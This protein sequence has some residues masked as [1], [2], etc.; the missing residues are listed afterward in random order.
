MEVQ[1]G[2]EDFSLP[3]LVDSSQPV[4]GSKNINNPTSTFV[5]VIIVCGII[6][7]A[8]ILFFSWLRTR[9]KSIYS[10]RLILLHNKVFPLGKLPSSFFAWISPAFMINDEDIFNHLG[11]DALTYLRFLRLAIKAV[12]L[13]LPYG[14]VVLIPLNLHGGMNLA[15]GLDKISMS[16]IKQESPKLWAHFLAVWIYSISLL[17][18]INDEWKVYVLYRQA[19]MAKG[20]GKQYALLVRDIPA[21]V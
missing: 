16:N 12:L 19:Y 14:I 18:L 17:Y 3:T 7:V 21:E 6:F 10:P 2:E 8:T 1:N 5:V 11:L 20:L 9:L 15:E 4:G 13:I